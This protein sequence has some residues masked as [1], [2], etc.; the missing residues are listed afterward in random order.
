MRP[1]Q[2]DCKSMDRARE[3]RREGGDVLGGGRGGG[4]G[5]TGWKE[6]ED[7]TS[8]RKRMRERGGGG[9]CGR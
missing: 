2:E 6:G 4:G 9:Q 5:G 1:R 8:K 7:S 3:D